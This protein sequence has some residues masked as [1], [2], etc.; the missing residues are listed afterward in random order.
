MD[1]DEFP[2]CDLCLVSIDGGDPQR[3][4][5]TRVVEGMEVRTTGDDLVRAR[6]ESLKKILA[7]H[8]HACLTCAQKEGCSLTECSMNV[9]EEERCCELLGRCE[10]GKVAE[11][12]GIPPDTPAYKPSGVPVI[13]DEPLF[14]R[15]Y[16]ICIGCLR[17]VR[18]CREVREVDALGAVM[19]EG[20]VYVG[21]TEGST[22]TEAECRFCGACVEVCPTGALRDHT[23]LEPLVDGKAPCV[24]ACPLNVDIPGYLELISRGRDYDALELIRRQAVLPGVLG[25]ACFHP[26]EDV[27][28]RGEI[29]EASAICSLK[30]FVSDTSGNMPAMISKPAATG[31]RVGV[32]GGG[33]AGLAVA[34][35]LLRWGHSVT[36]LDRDGKLGGMLRQAIPSF[37]LPDEVIDSDLKYIFDLGLETRVG[38]SLGKD[39]D[40]DDLLGEGF[41]AVII[42]VGLAEAM[43]L[44]V[45]GEDLA[46]IYP[47]LDFLYSAAR[48]E[49]NTLSDPVVVIGGGS[50]AVDAAMTA[51]RNGANRVTMVCLE[52]PDEMP[53][54]KD[55]LDAAVEEGIQVMNGWG[56]AGFEGDDG[57]VARVRL[58]RCT[59]VFDNQGRFSPEYDDSVTEIIQAHNVITAVG[60][61]AEQQI[62]TFLSVKRGVFIAGDVKTGPST[63]VAAMADGKRIASE[64]DA[65]IGG[66]GHEPVE[67]TPVEADKRLGRE[68]GFAG[69][70]RAVPQR[71]EAAERVKTMDVIEATLTAKEARDEADRCLRCHLRAMLMKAPLPP[72]PWCCF[73][74]ELLEEI[75]AVEGVVILAD[76]ARKTLKIMGSADINAAVGELLN[77]GFEAAVCRWELDPM[78]TK[79]ESELLQAYLQEHGELPGTDDL[80]DLF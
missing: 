76:G 42:A 74:P 47:G 51:R 4:C 59:Q 7:N 56:V 29:N 60:Q 48:G 35:E 27:C 15:D 18:I 5:T 73:A 11:Y 58:K 36:I 2:Y 68:P 65:F 64:V 22:L 62:R 6:R 52:A 16:E 30:R 33:P 69:R 32:I 75:P 10:I 26:C 25:Y 24:A 39:F 20:R 79:R 31:K 61:R 3:A 45:E 55:E 38:I 63:I 70:M 23:G 28:R 67:E 1:D 19:S 49:A 53:A 21:T 57:H 17:C 9:A 12:I 50:V 54:T 46:C 44:K 77:D 80:D 41:D 14:V 72:D 40:V 34:A 66:T 13:R 78:Y 8:P 43:E 37:R 71:I